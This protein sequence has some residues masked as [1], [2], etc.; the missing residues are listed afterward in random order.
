MDV[1]KRTLIVREIEHWRRSKLLPEQYCDFLLNLYRDEEVNKD[2]EVFG[3]ST[4][5]VQNSSWLGWLLSFGV[6]SLICFIALHFNSFALSMQ[7]AVIG[8]A[9]V[10]L[11]C[12]GMI[13]RTRKRTLAVM[14]FGAGSILML[15]FGI[16]FLT[17]SGYAEGHLTALY[18]AICGLLWIVLGITLVLPFLHL[19]G[20]L[21]LVLAYGWWIHLESV[22]ESMW[23]HELY[24]IPAGFFLCWLAWLVHHRSKSTSGVLLMA[25]G[26]LWLMPQ[27]YQLLVEQAVE[28]HIQW[29]GF[30]KLLLAGL[31][32]FVSRK[33]WTE[34]VA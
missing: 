24:W 12:A 26:L 6:I 17:I 16:H 22:S 19:C 10:I 28:S 7:M 23:I 13:W 29:I 30:G 32:L 11:Y 33:K 2:S 9:V 14:L 20:W 18:I 8:A 3:I 27:L 25:G 15:W 1:E 34:W 31:I 21:G 4:K 5:F